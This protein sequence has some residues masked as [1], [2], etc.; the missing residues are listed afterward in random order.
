MAE[1]YPNVQDTVVSLCQT[2]ERVAGSSVL[3]SCMPEN[4]VAESGVTAFSG[5]IVNP[6]PSC[7][8][9]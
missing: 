4:W 6:L 3:Y 9:A 8:A 7:I 5:G 2:M 1:C